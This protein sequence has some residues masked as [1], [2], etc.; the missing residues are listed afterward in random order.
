M[1]MK[2]PAA[3]DLPLREQPVWTNPWLA[4][5]FCDWL[6]GGPA[7]PNHL[8][9]NLQCAALLFV[10]VESAHTGAVVDVPSYL[11]RRLYPAAPG[12]NNKTQQ[13]GTHV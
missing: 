6:R 12:E 11:Q 5:M 2:E 3:E 1:F 8:D 13:G 10:A 7:P 9:D 4:E